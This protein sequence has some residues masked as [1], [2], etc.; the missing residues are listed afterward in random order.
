MDG[1]IQARPIIPTL[2]WARKLSTEMEVC[3]GPGNRKEVLCSTF[4]ASLAFFVFTGSSLGSLLSSNLKKGSIHEYV[5]CSCVCISLLSTSSTFMSLASSTPHIINAITTQC[6]SVG[7]AQW[8]N[9]I[10][11]IKLIDSCGQCDSVAW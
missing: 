6:G 7:G 8:M 5:V 4:M 10:V 11:V 1:S 9:I 2:C 3:I